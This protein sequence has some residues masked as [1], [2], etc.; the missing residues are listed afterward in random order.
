MPRGGANKT[1]YNGLYAAKGAGRT[2]ERVVA[3][4]MMVCVCGFQVVQ[5]VVAFAFM[6]CACGF[7]AA[8]A[9]ES[10]LH[11]WYVFEFQRVVA[12]SMLACDCSLAGVPARESLSHSWYVFVVLMNY[13][14]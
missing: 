9:S 13:S 3:F 2:E 5:R 8:P 6:V 7:A 1:Y 14:G 10:L 4:K 12:F 11:S